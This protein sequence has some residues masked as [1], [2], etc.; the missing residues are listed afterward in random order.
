MCHTELLLCFSFHQTQIRYWQ[1]CILSGD[2]RD[3]CFH[4]HSRCWLSL[5]TWSCRAGVPF[6]CLLLATNLYLLNL[7]CFCSY[8]YVHFLLCVCVCVCVCVFS[9]L[10]FVIPLLSVSLICTLYFLP[11]GYL[12]LLS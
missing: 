4:A 10:I 6:A 11:F 5:V 9:K 8:I 1:D 12:L 3:E 2:S 7:Y